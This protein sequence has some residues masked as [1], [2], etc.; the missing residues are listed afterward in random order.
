VGAELVDLLVDM[1][2]FDPEPGSEALETQ[3]VWIALF[4]P[5]QL[6]NQVLM[7]AGGE[8]AHTR[9]APRN[10]GLRFPLTPKHRPLRDLRAARRS[11]RA[12]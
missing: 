7:A 2:S 3:R 5:S 9:R 1:L 4:D 12:S 11:G 6:A 10:A 8:I